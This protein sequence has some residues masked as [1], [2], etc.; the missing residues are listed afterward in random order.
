MTSD[1]W[2]PRGAAGC[3]DAGRLHLSPKTVE[4]NIHQILGKLGI[5]E[6]PDVNR[7]VVAVLAYLRSA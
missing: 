7:R 2:R 4:A 1:V 3:R 6:A 5:A